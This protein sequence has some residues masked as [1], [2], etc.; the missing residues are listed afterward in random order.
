MWIV[1][2]VE[3]HYPSVFHFDNEVEA[4]KAYEKYKD[5]RAIVHIAEVKDTSFNEE[6]YD[7]SHKNKDDV[8]TWNVEWYI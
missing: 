6:S 8:K 5:D 7:N 3:E 1:V 2:V 4:K